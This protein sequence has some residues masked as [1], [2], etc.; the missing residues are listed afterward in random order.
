MTEGAF[1]GKTIEDS[2]DWK[3][4]GISFEGNNEKINNM[5]KVF[6]LHT[7]PISPACTIAYSTK[8]GSIASYSGLSATCE[9]YISNFKPL[10]PMT[11]DAGWIDEFR[12]IWSLYNELDE[13]YSF[14]NHAIDSFDTLKRVPESSDL[15]IV[16]YLSIIE[17]LIT[18]A[19]R[20]AESLDSINHQ[21]RNKM[22]LL[23]KRFTHRV[24][25]KDFFPLVKG[26]KR[27]C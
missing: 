3:Y 20:L 7:C 8:D 22:I 16:G 4:N 5:Q 10:M 21:F 11:I 24:D 2:Q 17:S 25:L 1:T 26:E 9:K 18:H 12:N 23:C 14:I 15:L 19:P 27:L 13:E 6:N